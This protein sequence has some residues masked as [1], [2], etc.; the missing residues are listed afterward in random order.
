MKDNLGM[1]NKIKTNYLIINIELH[2][3]TYTHIYEYIYVHMDKQ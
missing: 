3:Y 2:K 1:M